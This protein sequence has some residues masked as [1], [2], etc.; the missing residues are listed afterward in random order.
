MRVMRCCLARD[1][2]CVRH[3][4]QD[5]HTA[6]HPTDIPW[7][8]SVLTNR[9][10]TPRHGRTGTVKRQ[11][12]QKPARA[13]TDSQHPTSNFKPATGTGDANQACRVEFLISG[14]ST[15]QGRGDRILV[16]GLRVSGLVSVVVGVP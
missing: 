11:G 3:G 10:P 13:L 9:G 8:P 14:R 6:T 2:T 4:D 1:K 12:Q 5:L 7:V 15:R 16:S